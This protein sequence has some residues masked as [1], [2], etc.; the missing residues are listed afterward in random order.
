M[1]LKYDGSLERAQ[2]A[3]DQLVDSLRA[4]I[5]C[6]EKIT[7]SVPAEDWVGI[8]RLV[9]ELGANLKQKGRAQNWEP[10]QPKAVIKEVQAMFNELIGRTEL[11]LAVDQR[12]AQ[13]VVPALRS[14]FEYADRWYADARQEANSL[15]FDDLEQKVLNLLQGYP[16]ATRYWQDSIQALLVDEYQDTNSR[17]RQLVN[18]LNGEDPGLFIVGDGKQSI[19][20]FRGADVAVFREEQ[21]RVEAE[22]ESYQLDR[23]Y[24]P[25]Q[26]LLQ[27][28]NRLMGPVLG[29]RDDL[30]Y[31][32]PFKPLT[33]GRESASA[34]ELPAYIEVHLAAGSRSGGAGLKAAQAIAQRL[35]EL[36]PDGPD[37]A[38]GGL[39]FGGAAVL[40][41]ASRSFRDFERAFDAAG[42]PYTTVSGQGFFERPEIRDVLNAMAAFQDP[43]ND[44][45]LAGL[46]RSPV[47]GFDDPTLLDLREYQQAL[48]LGSLLEGVRAYAS[49]QKGQLG[50]DLKTFLDLVEEF[51]NLA[52]RVTAAEL[53]SRFLERTDYGAGLLLAGQDR[54]LGNLRKLVMDAQTSGLVNLG[55]FLA[56]VEEIRA[57]AI[58]E[59][60]AQTAAQGAGQIMTVHQAKGL[61]FPIV[62]LGDA[63]KREPFTRDLLIDERFGLVPPF[64]LTYL[65]EVPGEAPRIRSGRSM[66]YEIALE[67]ERLKEEAESR[68]LLYVA[69]TRAQDLLLISGAV[70][71]PTR[72][73]KLPK[74]AGWL[75]ELGGPLGLSDW[76]PILD[77]EG[78]AIHQNSYRSEDLAVELSIYEKGADLGMRS[79]SPVKGVSA[80][81][82]EIQAQWEKLSQTPQVQPADLDRIYPA[83]KAGAAAH[84]PA[85]DTGQVVHR[86]LKL[87]KF[88][89]DGG[90]DFL[91]W[92]AVG[93]K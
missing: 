7:R 9:G 86:A 84:I 25:H 93:L 89:E 68:R 58:R 62:I 70:G 85:L 49:I 21:K 24:R 26:T 73:G 13:E 51:S 3:G 1:E 81:E 20:R 54:A 67:S 14:L 19:Y 44:L 52:G 82:E 92:S 53:I 41:R 11:D 69:A 50:S 27:N 48:G 2:A 40:C 33:A 42:I 87:W 75:A 36:I 45:A 91:A 35:L 32:E 16:A 6:W 64:S 59:G 76:D 56:A 47:I 4:V 38:G 17:Q 61:E 90:E 30:P 5:A 34:V 63:A 77:P 57:V 60:E 46:L 72:N 43:T 10:A 78:E 28:L 18:I 79:R 88:P 65:E 29:D 37:Q 23:S 83:S 22:G 66:A 74:L 80:A 8:S 55:D 31:L 71:K 15:D 12:L 39:T